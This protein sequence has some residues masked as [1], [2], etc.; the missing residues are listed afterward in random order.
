MS[1]RL[2][3]GVLTGAYEATR[4]KE[5]GNV[6]LLEGVQLLGLDVSPSNE[7][8]SAATAFAS[9]TTVAR[10]VK[11]P[12]VDTVATSIP[13]GGGECSEGHRDL[14]RLGHMIAYRHC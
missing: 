3:A 9:G 7:H 13:G 14:P 4:F 2:A 10:Y 11:G 5:K 1:G 8:L 6:S 12:F